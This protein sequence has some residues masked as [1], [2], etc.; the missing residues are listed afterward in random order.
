MN[1]MIVLS[2]VF[3][4]SAYAA[5]TYNQAGLVAHPAAV[6]VSVPA[7][8]KTSEVRGA[9]V[10]TIHQ[11]APVVSKQVHLGESTYVSGYSAEII[12]PPTPVLPIAVPTALKGT[13]QVNAP[14]VKSI[15]ETHVVNEPAPYETRVEVPYDAPVI[16]EQI[17][18][19][20]VPYHVA[21]PYAVHVPTPVRGEPIVN[22][23]QTAPVVQRH[24]TNL[25]AQPAVAYAGHAYQGAYAQGYAGAGLVN[26]NQG[27]YALAYGGEPIAAKTH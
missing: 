8:Y 9:P 11:G 6:P 14:L 21:K 26:L 5:P 12:K 23:Q 2:T 22:V 27:A 7:P 10:T 24:H 19:V 16:R 25:V 20:P 18:E 3:A 15:T 4:A 17:K 13:T 1:P